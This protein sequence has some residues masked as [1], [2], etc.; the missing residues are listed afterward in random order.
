MRR[1]G[2]L[3]LGIL[4]SVALVVA[5]VGV[6]AQGTIFNP[7]EVAGIASRTYAD[8]EVRSG[9][10]DFV[11]AQALS[12]IDVEELI[13]SVLPDRLSRLSPLAP[14]IAG[15]VEANLHT[16][17]ESLLATERA[18]ELVDFAARSA[19][20]SAMRVLSGQS[21]VGG[22]S[23]GDGEVR[24]NLLP[25]ISRALIGAQGL[26][27]LDRLSI[28]E[29]GRDGDPLDQLDELS[30]VLGRPLPAD[31]GQLVIYRGSQV[32]RAQ[33]TV[34][35]AQ[36][37][38]V[39]AHRGTWLAVAV[40]LLAGAGSVL[41][42]GSRRRAI[43]YLS[44]AAGV[45]LLVVRSA[46]PV[47]IDQA[48]QLVANPAGSAAVATALKS[49]TIGLG[50]VLGLLVLAATVVALVS[51]ATQGFEL[52]QLAIAL[53]AAAVAMIVLIAGLST[54]T[55][56]AGIAAGLLVSLATVLRGPGRWGRARP[57]R[58]A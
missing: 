4:A 45:L 18:A 12:L 54:L 41:A 29:F 42:A 39:A 57:V 31:F 11:T 56:V 9:L 36:R 3:A 8:A 25:L 15:S 48:S 30:A 40:T 51:L 38:V 37:I 19:H 52:R 34:S 49:T 24:L 16:R 2:S 50:S 53:G 26:G 5:T 6:W 21:P 44:L 58:S 23:V 47:V 43:L 55:L 35:L 14:M 1:A 32:D 22:V 46:I 27:V 20:S 33:T 28:P 17:V 7:D 10:A 13:A